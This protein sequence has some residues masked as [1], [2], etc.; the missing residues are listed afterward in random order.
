M[1]AEKV[2]TRREFQEAME[3]GYD[4]FQGYFFARPVTVKSREIGGYRANYLNILREIHK[5]ELD[6]GPLGKL[7]QTEVSLA[8]RLLRYV[9]SAAFD[10]RQRIGSIELA[11]SLL[12]D[13][14]IRKWLWLA[15]LPQLAKNKPTELIVS[16]AIRARFCE[17]IA[18]LARLSDHQPELF[19]MGMF[20]FL[21]AMLDRPLQELIGELHLAQD[22]QEA[23]L[24][25]GSPRNRLAMVLDLVQAYET[26]DWD[27]CAKRADR[28]ALPQELLP[29]LYLQSVAWAEKIF[30]R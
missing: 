29:D 28:L 18:P 19:L 12:G 20:S 21:D 30:P 4:Y 13:D 16:A 8:H 2:E 14:G 27:G 1:L 11:M 7:I 23:L 17:L 24:G 9:N 26:A 6:R 25:T 22:V 5:P 15:A 10:H 3:M